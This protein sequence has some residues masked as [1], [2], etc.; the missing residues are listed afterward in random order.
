MAGAFV[1]VAASNR[2][3]RD[4]SEVASRLR[5]RLSAFSLAMDT[6]CR[7]VEAVQR[8]AFTLA[9]GFTLTDEERRELGAI[10]LRLFD[11]QV[12]LND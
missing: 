5:R 6:A 9:A 8:M 2:L 4:A 7:D 12:V 1:H 3:P 11:A 10:A